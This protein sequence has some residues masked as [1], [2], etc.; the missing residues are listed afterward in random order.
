MIRNNSCC[1]L[2]GVLAGITSVSAIDVE[3]VTAK[4]TYYPGEL[5]EVLITVT[6]AGTLDFGST[7][8]TLYTMD[9]VY[10]PDMVGL[11]IVT[12][13]TTPYTWSMVHNWND[14][15]IS[16]GNHSV[17]G[18][19]LRYGTSPSAD[20]E[21]VQPPTPKGDFLIDFETIPATTAPVAH[22]IAYHASGI[23][24][25]TS[26]GAA[27]RLQQGEGGSWVEG[28]DPYPTGFN[29][30]AD[31]AIPVFGASAKVAGGTDVRITMKAK[32]AQGQIIAT[33]VSDPITQPGQFAQTLSVEAKEPIAS[34][35]WWPSVPNSVMGVDDLFVSVS[36]GNHHRRH[37]RN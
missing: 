21:V 16:L 19:V 4:P 11:A 36:L 34:L 25:R 24:F 20:F 18:T 1:I 9:S 6:N 26:L 13:V 30:V 31:F 37:S 3:V 33:A 8:Q 2:A 15:N 35:E 14:Y 10:T 32:N 7:L 22:L 17:V 27:C 28:F 23:D 12:Q 29:V 5:V